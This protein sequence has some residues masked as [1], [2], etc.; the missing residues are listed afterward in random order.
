MLHESGVDVD[1][2]ASPDEC[3]ENSGYFFG[4]VLTT[5]GGRRSRNAACLKG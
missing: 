5:F 2:L 1:R 4:C 3:A